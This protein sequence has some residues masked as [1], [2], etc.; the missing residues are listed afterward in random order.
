MF[1]LRER[2][3]LDS[4][5]RD[6]IPLGGSGQPSLRCMDRTDGLLNTPLDGRKA[7]SAENKHSPITF[8]DELQFWHER[9]LQ[10]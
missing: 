9:I 10:V 5:L 4:A 6:D 8:G 2:R 1:R 3:W 7:P